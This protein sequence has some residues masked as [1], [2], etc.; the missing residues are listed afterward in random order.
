[1][2]EFYGL[3]IASANAGDDTTGGLEVKRGPNFDPASRNWIKGFNH[4][5]LRLTRILRSLRVLGLID[6]AK[7]LHGFL[8]TDDRV[9]DTVSPRS[10][11]YWR[12]AAERELRLPP[13]EEDEEAEGIEWLRGQF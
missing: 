2:L 9:L 10:Q 8:C 1:M 13:D 6:E 4:N 5:H 11:M 7:A 3:Q 12:R